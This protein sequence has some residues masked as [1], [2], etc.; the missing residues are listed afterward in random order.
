MLNSAGTHGGMGSGGRAVGM[1]GPR[2]ALDFETAVRRIPPLPFVTSRALALVR[3]PG[4]R[5][6]ELAQ[7]LS[8]DE[9]MTALFLRMVNS[10]FYGLPRRITS[11]DEAIGYLGYENTKAVLF[12]VSTRQIFYMGVP[13]YMLD[14]DALWHHSVAVAAGSVW[15]ARQ[16]AITPTSEV[17]VAGLLHDIGKLV[18]DIMVGHEPRWAETEGSDGELPWVE[19]ERQTLGCDHAELGAQAVHAWRLPQRVV[20]AVR[21]HH[22]PHLAVLDP[23]F[24]ATVHVANAASL[25]AGVG[26]GIDGLQHSL[27]EWAIDCLQWT[28]PEMGGLLEEILRAVREAERTFAPTHR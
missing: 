7:V 15:I 6:S 17:Y 4:S 14:R 16:R 5:R 24:A 20:E 27:E 21:T 12:A 10:A 9:G 25:M 8:L 19:I 11:L 23:S 26:L 1:P 13:S 3:D 2:P 28:E 22:N 18:L